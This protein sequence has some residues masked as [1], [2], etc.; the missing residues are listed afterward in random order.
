M[1]SSQVSSPQASQSEEASISITRLSTLLDHR[2]FIRDA[3]EIAQERIIFCSPFLNPLSGFSIDFTRERI[4][5]AL[6]REVDVTFV[7]NK[8]QR[9]VNGLKRYFGQT[10][11]THPHFRIARMEKFHSKTAV[12]DNTVYEGSFNWLSA[13][14]DERKR[15]HSHEA[16]WVIRDPKA[17]ESINAF[18]NQIN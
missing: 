3:F 4:L 6:E 16:G 14:R 1:P 13:C 11:T 7:L 8:Q 10:I 9:N 17:E 18:L 5:S 2:D 12:V 15:Y